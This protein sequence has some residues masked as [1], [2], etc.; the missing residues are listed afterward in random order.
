MN[1]FGQGMGRGGGRG[2]VEDE[3]RERAPPTV[4]P[5][6]KTPRFAGRLLCTTTQRHVIRMRGRP[7]CYS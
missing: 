5:G 2:L 3:R 6:Y 7:P 1:D 4:R